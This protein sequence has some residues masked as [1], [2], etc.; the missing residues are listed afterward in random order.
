VFH[1]IA[2]ARAGT[3]AKCFRQAINSTCTVLFRTGTVYMLI[4]IFYVAIPLIHIALSFL[5]NS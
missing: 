5:K 3:R 1:G 4:F 2:R